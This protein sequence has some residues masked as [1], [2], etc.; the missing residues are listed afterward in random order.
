MLKK[1]IQSSVWLCV[2]LLLYIPVYAQQLKL[3]DPTSSPIKAA[4]LELNTTNQGLLLPRVTDTTIA[5]L[6]ASP[7]GM[8]IYYTPASSLLVRRNGSWSKLADSTAVSSN[9]WLLSGNANIDSATKFIGTATANPVN[10]RTSNLNRMIISSTGRVG[11]GTTTPS[12]LL[13]VKTGTTN[14][15]GVRFENLTSASTVTA[16]AGGLGVDASGNVVRAASAP[17]FYNGAG[18]ISQSIKIWADSVSQPGTPLTSGQLSIDI[19][20]AGFTKILSIQ[21]TAKGGADYTNAPL[22][23]ILGYSLT[24]INFILTESRA[25]TVVLLSILDG[26]EPSIANT[27]KIFVTVIGY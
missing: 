12:S 9:Q 2:L 17:V 11:I 1:S 8:I 5:P 10:F 15:S 6:N 13:H 24:K 3:G 4:L 16:G 14:T 27:T 21:A 25:S 20:S 7:D 19:S 23:T 26:L 22:V 18:V